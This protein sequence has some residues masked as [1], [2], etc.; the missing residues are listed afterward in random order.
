[1]RHDQIAHDLGKKL[2]HELGQTLERN[3]GVA[4]VLLEPA[5]LSLMMIEAAVSF[6]LSTASSVAASS[7]DESREKMFDLTIAAV[8]NMAGGDRARALAAI[9]AKF[10]RV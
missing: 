5:E 8:T 2:Q 6:L 10:D 1:M 9:A 3:L 7:K 4:Q